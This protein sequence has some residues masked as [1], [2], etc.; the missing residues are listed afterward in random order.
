MRTFEW[1]Y[2]NYR[3]VVLRFAIQCVGRRELAEEIT[4]EAFL[5]LHQHWASIQTDRLPSWLFTVVKNRAADYW[6]RRE[7]EKRY[8]AAETQVS[9]RPRHLEG[10]GLFDNAALKAVHRI[11]LTLRYVHDMS[12]KEIA[13]RLGLTEVQ[14][15]G[16]LQYARVILR[17]QFSA[18]T[19][20]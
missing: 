8:L 14:V 19:S 17:K 10:G 2:S 4:A 12:V 5:E 20:P 6:R 7:L 9:E 15:K 11:C 13:H 3:D 18:E 1:A 16:H